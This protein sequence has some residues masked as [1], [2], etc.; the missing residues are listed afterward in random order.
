MKNCCSNCRCCGSAQMV[1]QQLKLV[2]PLS[3][4][5]QVHLASYPTHQMQGHPPT[6]QTQPMFKVWIGERYFI[7]DVKDH[8]L[9][10]CITTGYKA[11]YRTLL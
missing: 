9:E 10:T 1:Q 3:G 11:S 8:N 2:A 6:V 7:G 4:R 5:L